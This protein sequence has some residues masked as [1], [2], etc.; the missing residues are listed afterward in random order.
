GARRD[1]AVAARPAAVADDPALRR[2]DRLA[3]PAAG[4]GDAHRLLRRHA[5][6]RLRGRGTAARGHDGVHDAG[7]GPDLP[8]LQ[9]AV[10]APVG[11]HPAI[12]ERV[13]PGSGPGVPDPPAGGG[14]LAAAADRAPHGAT[15][16]VGL[17]GPAGMGQ[18]LALNMAAHGYRVAVYNRTTAVM[19]KFVAGHGDT[20]G[21][22]V[23][24]S[25]LPA[26]GAPPRKPRN[27]PIRA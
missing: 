20:P 14:L 15:H 3:G 1:E 26:F 4:G 19:E 23:G 25:A 8:R 24:F 12:H 21:G 10:A 17:S 18:N 22:L 27:T 16:R 2:A 9:R 13:A 6:V 5:L 11:V 7:P